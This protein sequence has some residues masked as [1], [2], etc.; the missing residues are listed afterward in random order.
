[1]LFAA[2][3]VAAD[4]DQNTRV[5]GRGKRV[6]GAASFLR[7][8]LNK[9]DIEDQN[10]AACEAVAQSIERSMTLGQ[11]KSG[12][13]A[14]TEVLVDACE[15]IDDRTMVN[16]LQRAPTDESDATT[17]SS[18]VLQF[19]TFREAELKQVMSMRRHG[20]A[21][22]AERVGLSEY[23][24]ALVDEHEESLVATMLAA[25]PLD[26]AD[27]AEING[28]EEYGGT[29]KEH[30]DITVQMCLEIT[31]SCTVPQLQSIFLARDYNREE[32]ERHSRNHQA[33]AKKGTGKAKK[34]APKAKKHAP[35]KLPATAD[36]SAGISYAFEWIQR[37]PLT[38][39]VSIAATAALVYVG[40]LVAR[41]W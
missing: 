15:G 26:A 9:F 4:S 30:Y 5:L 23:C 20:A 6:V 28:L 22:T 19:H 17:A 14:A 36:A 37:A 21:P 3:V 33:K 40:G 1:M 7:L 8:D 35:K 12:G 18:S 34:N 27:A 13:G 29:A 31:K 25:T 10:C 39:A 38:A 2:I 16:Q 24:S 32:E 41:V 11:H